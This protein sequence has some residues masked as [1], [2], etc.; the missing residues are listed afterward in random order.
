MEGSDRLLT[1]RQ[2]AAY[3]EVP[4]ATLTPGGTEGMGLRVSG[5]E[6]IS[7]TGGQTSRSG[8]NAAWRSHDPAR[9]LVTPCGYSRR[10]DTQRTNREPDNPIF[11]SS[12]PT[13]EVT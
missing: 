3:L 10:Q 7:A 4:L 2:L 8:S 12:L 13:K 9:F 6:S 11:H 5:S 1:A